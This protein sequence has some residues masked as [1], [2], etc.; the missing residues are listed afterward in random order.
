VRRQS[1]FI[2][3][4]GSIPAHVQVPHAYAYMAVHMQGLGF[5]IC[6]PR[7]HTPLYRFIASRFALL[8][9]LSPLGFH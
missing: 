9:S 5:L 1:V 7:G 6:G 4:D 8:P 2:H 3:V